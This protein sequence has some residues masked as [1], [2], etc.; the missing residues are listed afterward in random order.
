MP[1]QADVRRRR[2]N[3]NAATANSIP[4]HSMSSWKESISS[5]IRDRSHAAA[6][7]SGFARKVSI[8]LKPSTGGWNACQLPQ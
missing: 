1:D 7:S 5:A 8:G 4:F 2:R 6:I 3:A